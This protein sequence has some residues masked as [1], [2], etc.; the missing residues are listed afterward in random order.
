MFAG[1]GGQID[2]IRGAT[3]CTDGQGKPIIAMPS[4]TKDGQS[5][6]VKFIKEGTYRGHNYKQQES[7]PVACQLPTCRP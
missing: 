5:R 2:F 4:T 3:L 6:I 7:I 1:V